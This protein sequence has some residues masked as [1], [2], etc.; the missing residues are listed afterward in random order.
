MEHINLRLGSVTFDYANYDAE[1]DILYL[2]VGESEPSEAEDTPEGHSIHYAMG[3]E[4]IVA[5]TIFSPRYILEH[6]GRLTVT[7]PEAVETRSAEDMAD[8]LAAV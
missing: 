5:L 3:A 6:E 8:A 4:R 7:L 2:R 1:F